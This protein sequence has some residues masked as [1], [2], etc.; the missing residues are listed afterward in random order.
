MLINDSKANKTPRAAE[1]RPTPIATPTPSARPAPPAVQDGFAAA[2]TTAPATLVPLTAGANPR[3]AAAQRGRD[4]LRGPEIAG[5][6]GGN[7]ATV[8]RDVGHVNDPA[9][10]DPASPRYQAADA[11][12]QENRGLEDQSLAAMSPEDRANYQQVRT[13]VQATGDKVA[14]LSLQTMLLEGKLPGA[15]DLMG[16]GTTLD[17]LAALAD[18]NTPLAD[19]IDRG[20]LLTDVVQEVATPSAIAQH[21]KNT[22]VP[23][24]VSLQLAMNNPAEYARIATGLAS[25]SGEVQLA[26]GQTLTREADT[27]ADDG[28]GRSVSQRLI[29]PAFMEF[30]NGWLD[31]RSGDDKHFLGPIPTFPGAPA[32]MAD[33]LLEAIYGKGMEHRTGILFGVMDE[34]E[35]QTAAGGS[36]L[37][38]L[39]WEDGGIL[40]WHKIVV[41]GMETVDGQEYVK[42]TNPWGQEERMPREEFERRLREANWDPTFGREQPAAP[43]ITPEPAPVPT[44][45]VATPTPSRTPTPEDEIVRQRRALEV[46]A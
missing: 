33:G 29:E 10:R 32:V 45:P 6:N 31:Y 3:D 5:S 13:Q 7:G 28:V 12:L 26:G 19:G 46:V 37:A 16:Q 1:P 41:T 2:A 42:Y 8:T 24:A 39:S 43:A 15:Q 27:L 4:F 44:P 34:I 22:C 20:A 9:D 35:R 30:A 18:P 21:T 40:Q 25:P 23:T 11:I 36:V 14:E 17:N 38:T